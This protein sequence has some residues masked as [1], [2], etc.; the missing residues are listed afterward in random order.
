MRPAGVL[1]VG[2]AAL[3]LSLSSGKS[4][5]EEVRLPIQEEAVVE[6][7]KKTTL[8]EQLIESEYKA[9]EKI[10]AE[11]GVN[12]EE[13]ALDTQWNRKYK[14][15]YAEV[16]DKHV[17]KLALNRYS[18]ENLKPLRELTHLEECY[19]VRGKVKKIE[20]L[21]NLTNLKKLHLQGNVIER[22][23]GL[24]NLINLEELY[25]SNNRITKIEGLENLRKLKKL[26]LEQNQIEKIE[27]LSSLELLEW[28]HLGWNKIKVME[29][30]NGL[31]NLQYLFLNNNLLEKAKAL[32]D[33]KKLKL[34]N[35]K[36]NKITEVI[37]PEL[38]ELMYLVVSYNPLNS[39]EG[40]EKVKQLQ[41]LYIE[42]CNFTKMPDLSKFP[43][44]EW[45]KAKGNQIEKPKDLKDLYP[46]VKIEIDIPKAEEIEIF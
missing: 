24:S 33:W 6:P 39:I 16:K 13:F 1:G 34:F 23:Q 44:L 37:L 9:L 45:V 27:G 8:K 40:L 22:I 30:L 29:G 17:V 7:E 26:F 2:L 43:N 10:A 3:V 21:E 11:A 20:G 41:R 25:L 46:K 4:L 31:F 12:V 35:L 14:S 28:L 18:L 38:A 5:A 42:G 19:V 15:F 32:E 36:H